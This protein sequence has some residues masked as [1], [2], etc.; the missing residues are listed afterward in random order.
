MIDLTFNSIKDFT[1][2]CFANSIYLT[3]ILASNNEIK[4]ISDIAFYNLA[5][6]VFL[7][8]SH[9]HL[10]S[11]TFTFI[12]K[13]RSIKLLDIQ[14]NNFEEYSEHTMFHTVIQYLWTDYFY[15]C[16]IFSKKTVCINK[17]PWYL[18]CDNIVSELYI[19]V[20]TYVICVLIFLLNNMC[21]TL[22]KFTL[23]SKTFGFDI[24]ITSISLMD[25]SYGIYLAMLII[26]EYFVNFYMWT[27][28]PLCFVAFA[29]FFN[30]NISS[31]LL[32]GLSTLSRF[33]ITKYPHAK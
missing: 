25:M 10:S 17:K 27:S 12:E 9:N 18:S 11:I 2:Y 21:I 28:N 3:A 15:H 5:S 26:G 16:C 7:N 30:Y 6:L 19:K 13:V 23:K 22:K 31:P 14:E 4:V 33:M 1:S 29:L 8:L 20:P 32:L 24:I